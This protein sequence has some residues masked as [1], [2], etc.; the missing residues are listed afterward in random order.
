[1][2]PPFFIALGRHLQEKHASGRLAMLVQ[3]LRQKQLLPEA[4]PHIPFLEPD[5]PEPEPIFV[6]V[7]VPV[8][9]KGEVNAPEPQPK[10]K[11]E[12]AEQN[13]Q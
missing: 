9:E 13:A 11:S 4:V 12:G 10:L 1:M 2:T 6:P 8:K 3:A 7:P 5:L